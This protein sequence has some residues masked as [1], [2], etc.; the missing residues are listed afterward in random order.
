MWRPSRA[1]VD[2][3]LHEMPAEEMTGRRI[4]TDPES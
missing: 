2:I 1:D 4:E 3:R